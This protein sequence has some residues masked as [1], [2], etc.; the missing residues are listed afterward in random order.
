MLELEQRPR[1]LGDL[2]SSLQHDSAAS[3]A[4]CHANQGWLAPGAS[5]FEPDCTAAGHV[6]RRQ[7]ELE[8]NVSSDAPPIPDQLCELVLA[9]LG[10]ERPIPVTLDA[11]RRLFRAWCRCTGWDTVALALRSIELR[12]GP[13]TGFPAPNYFRRW[14]A[15]GISDV[16]FANSEALLALLRAVG[17]ATERVLGTG[18]SNS[19]HGSVLVR[20]DDRRY[21]VDPTFLAEE[22]LPLL[23]SERSTAG[24]GPLKVWADT[25]GTIR[26]Q[27]PQCRF[28]AVFRIE[29]CD[30]SFA[31]F[32]AQ[33]QLVEAGDDEHALARLYHDKL[34]V[35]RN[36]DGG[37]RTYDNGLIISKSERRSNIAKAIGDQR[38]L[39][40]T[41][42]G[43]AT[44]LVAQIPP[45]F[46]SHCEAQSPR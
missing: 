13:V 20:I 34:F 7:Q 32:R 25:D 5:R 12:A 33:H 30:C 6:S 27:P 17:F 37:V 39:L 18:G 11:L 24:A 9:R 4:R 26:W 28:H 42:F 10:I 45:R 36:V 22:P 41:E 31:S 35:R 3:I 19:S 16:C 29:E 46:F 1:R 2:V 40:T 8:E 23:P 15:Y 44:E 43:I 21:L 38:H 14:L